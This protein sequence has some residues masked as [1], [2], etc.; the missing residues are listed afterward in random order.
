MDPTGEND[1]MMYISIIYTG[2]GLAFIAYPEAIAQMPVAPL[3]AI[4]FFLMMM[5]LGFSSEVLSYYVKAFAP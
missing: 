3:W 4:L 5:M 2:P 1:E